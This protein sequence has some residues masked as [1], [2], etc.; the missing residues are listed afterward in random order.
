VDREIAAGS[1]ELVDEHR[2]GDKLAVGIHVENGLFV[3][4]E[5]MANKIGL[6][7]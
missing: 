3:R 7:I 4:A 1:Y 5:L 6:G 2:P